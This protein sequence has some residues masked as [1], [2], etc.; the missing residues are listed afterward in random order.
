M[1]IIKLDATN[2]TNDYLK[3]LMRYQYLDNYTVVVTKRQ[4]KGRGQLDTSWQSDDHKNLTFSILVRDL[5]VDNNDIFSLNLAVSL[6]IFNVVNKLTKKKCAIKWPNDILAD[7]KK[8]AGILI[9]NNIH[10]NGEISSVIGIGLN[11]NQSIFIDLPKVTSLS[12]L[13][14]KFFDLDVVLDL[15]LNEFKQK[16]ALIKTNRK[17]E[18]WNIYHEVLFK[19]GIPTT[20]EDL[21]QQKFMGIIKGVSKHGKLQVLLENDTINEFALKEIKM[22]Y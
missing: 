1:H 11:V 3:Q 19:K 16:L 2:S 9:E 5:I 20:F 22:L 12:I 6:S 14:N 21:N 13:E 18:I 10:H 17:E 8:I 7:Q 4:K 15:I